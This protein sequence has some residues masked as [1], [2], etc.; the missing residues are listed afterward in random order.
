MELSELIL[1]I[2]ITLIV[3]IIAILLVDYGKVLT[4]FRK[5]N[6]K[7]KFSKVEPSVQKLYKKINDLNKSPENFS[8]DIILGITGESKIG[9]C[10]VGA[11]LSSQ[12]YF[13]T[14]GAGFA[15]IYQQSPIDIT[16]QA[17]IQSR[18]YKNILLVDDESQS[19][20]TMINKLIEYKA[21][22][23]EKTIKAAVIIARKQSV[24]EIDKAKL[25]DHFVCVYQDIPWKDK[26]NNKI[27]EVNWPWE[28]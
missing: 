3:G 20:T 9:G 13:N 27:H 17:H 5:P 4:S 10:I 11:W 8:P 12:P 7:H 28:A 18:N 23:P 16:L 19:G 2:L 26:T 6:F 22:F 1:T 24:Y 15:T 21:L 25:S 14:A